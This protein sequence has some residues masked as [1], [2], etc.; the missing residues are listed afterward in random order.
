MLRTALRTSQIAYC[1]SQ[2]EQKINTSTQKRAEKAASQKLVHCGGHWQ[3]VSILTAR[4]GS[5]GIRHCN[6]RKVACFQHKQR[7]KGKHGTWYVTALFSSCRIW[8]KFNLILQP[9][10][11]SSSNT[12]TAQAPSVWH[13][14]SLSPIWEGFHPSESQHM[15]TI[16][17]KRVSVEVGSSTGT[18]LSQGPAVVENIPL[19]MPLR[20]GNKDQEVSR[21]DQQSQTQQ[22][23]AEERQ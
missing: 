18:S 15:A 21:H 8:L 9:P 2:L 1:G 16:P 6:S 4:L 11:S 17:V 20:G 13:S 12:S 23:V 19:K 7:V 3:V 5:N 22:E 10:S 14:P